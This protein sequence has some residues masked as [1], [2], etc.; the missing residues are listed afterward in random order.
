MQKIHDSQ[1]HLYKALD[2]IL[3][4]GCKNETSIHIQAALQYLHEFLEEQDP[5][6]QPPEEK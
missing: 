5:S 3:S 4:G 6:A 2:G 1:E